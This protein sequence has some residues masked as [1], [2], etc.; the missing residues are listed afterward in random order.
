VNV[1]VPVTTAVMGG[2]VDVPTLAGTPARLRVPALTQ[3]GQVFRLKGYGMPVAGSTERGHLFARV[4][5]K[6][7]KTLTDEART[8][9]A[10]LAKLVEGHTDGTV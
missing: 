4:D 10:A 1:A 3:N 8:H 9:Y 7:P 5:A 6:L 2:H